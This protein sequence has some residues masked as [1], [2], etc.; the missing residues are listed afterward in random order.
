M[1]ADDKKELIKS[2]ETWN[3]GC[4]FKQNDEILCEIMRY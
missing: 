2:K 1:N 4:W 3:K